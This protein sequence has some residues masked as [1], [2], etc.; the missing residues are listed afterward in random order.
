MS[1]I[2]VRAAFN[3][4]D[5][6]KG[7][8][9]S[10]MAELLVRQYD[11]T[12]FCPLCYSLLIQSLFQPGIFLMRKTFS[13]MKYRTL[14]K[15]WKKFQMRNKKGEQRLLSFWRHSTLWHNADYRVYHNLQILLGSLIY[16]NLYCLSLL[17]L[18]IRKELQ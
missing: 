7:K 16:Q 1:F 4:D 11:M 18:W 3:S 14:M 2:K 15:V 9:K 5:M 12:V 17:D 10:D 6:A 8:G 13:K